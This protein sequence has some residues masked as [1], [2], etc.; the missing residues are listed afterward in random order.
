[1]R[2]SKR[3]PALPIGRAARLAFDIDEAREGCSKAAK[4][5]LRQK[6]LDEVQFEECARLDEALEQAHRLLKGTVRDIV[7]ARIERG[8]RRARSS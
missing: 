4:L 8:S 7:W 2:A 5:L 3:H 1:M 6:R